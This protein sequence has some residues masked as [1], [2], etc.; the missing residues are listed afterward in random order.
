MPNQNMT[1]TETEDVYST[2]NNGEA[3]LTYMKDDLAGKNTAELSFRFVEGSADGSE[4][5][6]AWQF[7]VTD[8]KYYI[9]KILLNLGIEKLPQFYIGSYDT[10]NN[11]REEFYWSPFLS[12][13]EVREN[14]W[15]TIKIVF[16]NENAVIFYDG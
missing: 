9:F 14:T 1:E 8:T 16:E 4:C 5:Y 13:E 7:Y 2:V 11:A 10:A 12:D 6:V 15:H 3:T